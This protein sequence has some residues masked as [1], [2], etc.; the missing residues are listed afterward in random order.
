MTENLNL[1]SFTAMFCLFQLFAFGEHIYVYLY[2]LE[3]LMNRRRINSVGWL[4]GSDGRVVDG[5]LG[6][7][8]NV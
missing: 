3:E 2:I 7:C 6:G 1:D 8:L 4:G 5:I